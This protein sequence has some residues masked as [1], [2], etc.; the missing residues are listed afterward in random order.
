MNDTLKYISKVIFKHFK[1]SFIVLSAIILISVAGVFLVER[2]VDMIDY[3]EKDS[4]IRETEKL[5]QNKFTGSMPVYVT[6]NGNIQSLEVLKMMKKVQDFME[7]NEYIK[8]TQE[9]NDVMGEGG[10]IPDEESKIQQLWFLLE[11]QD[12]M[13]QLVSDDLDEGLIQSNIATTDN[14]ALTA[15]SDDLEKFINK[16]QSKEYHM[17]ITGLPSLYKRLDE[18]IVR[19][20]MTSLIL[21]TILVFIAV[22]L[23]CY[24]LI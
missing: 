14:E 23:F 16:N 10:K 2:R 6:V 3:F 7:Q 4:E 12:I 17:E 1:Y 22:S 15:F 18:S 21:A 8:Q 19:S 9:M 20:Q 13:E 5:L 11:R 24:F